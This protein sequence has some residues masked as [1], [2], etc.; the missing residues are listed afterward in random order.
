MLLGVL[1]AVEFEA[2]VHFPG[3]Q[4][5]SAVTG[6]ELH[7]FFSSSMEL[8]SRCFETDSDGKD[9]FAVPAD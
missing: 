3:H 8:P 7:G 9:V 4:Y 5:I 1:P 6:V 2:N